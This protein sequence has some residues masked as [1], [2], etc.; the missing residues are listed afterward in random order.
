MAPRRAV[1]GGLVA[2]VGTGIALLTLLVLAIVLVPAAALPGS[3][4]PSPAEAS[5]APGDGAGSGAGSPAASASPPA[6]GS[7]G[8]GGTGG[9]SP[10]PTPSTESPFAVGEPAPPLVVRQLGGGTIDLASLRGRPVWVTFMATWCPACRE[11]LPRMALAAARHATDGLVVLAVDVGEDDGTVAAYFNELGVTLPVGLD[12]D[13]AAMER[14]RIL[15]LPVHFWI[16]AEGI[17]RFGAL[18]GVGPDVFAEG[19]ATILPGSS[20]AP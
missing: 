6:E 12:P 14:W 17:V 8:A 20:P 10:M 18:G 19:L 16:D 7:S 11:E 1:L 9:P 4:A 5:A 2:G 15:A 3:T 13:G